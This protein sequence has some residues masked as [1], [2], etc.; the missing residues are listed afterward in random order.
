MPRTD[1]RKATTQIAALEMAAKKRTQAERLLQQA[2]QI[3][4][5][6]NAYVEQSDE[7]VLARLNSWDSYQRRIGKHAKNLG[8]WHK[9]DTY[10]H[11]M[12][13]YRYLVRRC[14]NE[15]KAIDFGRLTKHM[16]FKDSYVRML[17][18]LLQG[19]SVKVKEFPEKRR[20]KWEINVKRGERLLPGFPL[21]EH[22]RPLMT[23]KPA[24]GRRP[25]IYAVAPPPHF[26]FIWEAEDA[27]LME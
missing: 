26:E 9:T 1:N 13:L 15:A 16:G 27:D 23:V 7:E 10:K 17:I 5:K 20:K 2:D 25:N 8:K 4:A 3:E 14:R 19:K 18:A 24:A 6:G 11:A 12:K 22:G 21:N